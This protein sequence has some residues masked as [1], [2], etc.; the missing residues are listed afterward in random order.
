MV[1][2]DE[3][4]VSLDIK[5]R[6]QLL[7]YD[8]PL[9]ATSGEEAVAKA[10]AEQPALIL[11]DIILDG[12][13]DGIEATRRIREKLNIPIIY[14][15]AYADEE[16]LQRA[17]ITEPFGYIIKPF[18][19][20]EL[21]TCIEMAI[22]KHNTEKRLQE[23]ER[24][25]ATTL[26]SIG[27][28]V[29][30]TDNQGKIRFINPVAEELIHSCSDSCLGRR[31]HDAVRIIREDTGEPVGDVVDQVLK[32][33][34]SIRLQEP[35]L[36]SGSDGIRRP[37]DVSASAIHGDNGEVLGVVLVIRD[38]TE[39]KNAEEALRKSL[40]DLR[41]TLE[42]TVTAL[43]MTTEKRDPYTSGHQQRVAKLASAM[44]REMG[45]DEELV[46]G[47]RVSALLHDI[48]KIYIPAEILSKPAT[49]TSMEMGIMK[50]HSEVGYDILKRVS[51]PWPVADIV[52]QHHERVD[53]SGY[54]N[55]LRDAE[56]LLEAKIIM[57]ADVVEAM[58]S[59][60][61]Y[62]AALGLSQ[63]LEEIT[64][65]KDSRYDGEVAD[66]CLSLFNEKGFRFE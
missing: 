14:L 58:S 56:I 55:G 37:V 28:A 7:G 57:V 12:E 52:L 25:L 41:R 45:L 54:P 65:F 39:S 42:E 8:E 4:V 6:L 47:I 33:E 21:Q 27:D 2:E 16:T 20:R 15:T 19:D 17:K 59:H 49:L 29:L 3:P 62:R 36:L 63:A 1:V 40:S 9:Q 34:R 43:A 31:F 53:G 5:K 24:W 38:I 51:F 18:E 22:Y 30:T 64:R 13:L 66:I 48:G 50:T 32:E 11:M 35:A 26:K 23:N 46:E 60:R 44:A 61:P 10:L